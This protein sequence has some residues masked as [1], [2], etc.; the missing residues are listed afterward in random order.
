MRDIVSDADKLEAI[1]IAGVKRCMEYQI[2]KYKEDFLNQEIPL[3]LLVKR[4]VE[5]AHEKL[6]RLRDH[7]IKTKMGKEISL[8]LHNEMVILVEKIDKE[9]SFPNHF[10]KI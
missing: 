5:H 1:G 3:L 6:L 10:F 4:V 2:H 7:F 9:K 8:P